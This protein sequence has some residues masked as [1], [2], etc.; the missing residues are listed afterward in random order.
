MRHEPNLKVDKYRMVHPVL[1]D[2]ES[3]ANY[4]FFV[5]PYRGHI[6]R[7]ISSGS[8]PNPLPNHHSQWE[9]VSVS[10][11]NRCPT[12]EEMHFVKELFWK[13][14]EVVMQLHPAK[15][16]YINCHPYTLHLWRSQID[17]IPL[18]PKDAV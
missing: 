14:D 4:G 13:D 17:P 5:I 7:A 11:E 2:S 16:N 1:G 6:L 3:G 10:L 12:W 9:H 8:S 18:P 15:E